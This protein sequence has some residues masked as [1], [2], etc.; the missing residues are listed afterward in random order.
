MLYTGLPEK[1]QYIVAYL[2][3]YPPA[4]PNS[5]RHVVTEMKIHVIKYKSLI[6]CY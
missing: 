3:S 4:P 1:S 2:V 5:R 6:E